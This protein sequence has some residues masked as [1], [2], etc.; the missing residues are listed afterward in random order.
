MDAKNEYEL[1]VS[2]GKLP[3]WKAILAAFFFTMMF[4]HLYEFVKT[5]YLV[6]LDDKYSRV[7]SD[8]MKG[9]GIC[10][11]VGVLLATRVMILINLEKDKLISRYHLGPFSRDR[12]TEIPE[13]EYVAVFFDSKE[14]FQVNLWYK[15]NKHFRMCHFTKKISAMDFARYVAKRLKIDLL[16]ATKK[17]DSKWIEPEAA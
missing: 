15:G 3:I 9:F 2:D 5:L 7:F 14:R 12:V 10:I 11:T 16:D 6:G 13:L 1:V 8:S 17:G 4:Y